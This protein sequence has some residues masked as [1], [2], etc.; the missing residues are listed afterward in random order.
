MNIHLANT[1]DPNA[2]VTAN[3]LPKIMNGNFAISRPQN[4]NMDLNLMNNYAR[5]SV[6]ESSLHTR[7]I[8][9]SSKSRG[10]SPSMVTMVKQKKF[11][12]QTD[13]QAGF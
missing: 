6:T 7:K 4:N 8:P 10:E 9:M 12:K 13:N 3:Q 2:R 5:D 1:L 11:S